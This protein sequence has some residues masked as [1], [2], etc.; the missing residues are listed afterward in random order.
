MLGPEHQRGRPRVFVHLVNVDFRL[1]ST[2]CAG[3]ALDDADH[4]LLHP[5]GI[6]TDLQRHVPAEERAARG[7]PGPGWKTPQQGAA[8]SVWAAV[9]AELDGVGGRYLEDCA[10]ARPWTGPGPLPRGHHLPYALDP[11]DAETLWTL[12][13][14]TTR[15]SRR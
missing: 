8:T 3:Q 9:A 4:L 14:T 13:E 11:D 10:I 6:A 5:G 1:W 2:E 7:W 15:Q 12:S